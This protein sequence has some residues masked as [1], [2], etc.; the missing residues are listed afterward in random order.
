MQPTD[1]SRSGRPTSPTNRVSPV[2]TPHGAVVVG[3]LPHDDRDRL[4]RVP[5]RVADLELDLT[6][7]QALA[8]GQGSIGKSADAALPYEIAAP[9]D[10]GQLEVTGQEVGVEMRLD[11]PL[12]RQ[13]LGRGFVEVVADVALRV[14]DDSTPGRFV[15][16]HVAEQR[17]ARELVL[18][19]VH[20]GQS[21]P[22][23]VPAA[24]SSWAGYA[25]PDSCGL[26]RSTN[27]ISPKTL[28]N[29]SCD[30]EKS[31]DAS[32]LRASASLLK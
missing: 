17:Q 25:G 4:G 13:P 30:P 27:V 21:I 5:R 15:T 31:S 9:V 22:R 11:D 23:R 8:V 32:P 16:D 10:F 7:R 28:A 3:V 2:R 14:D 24:F 19:E 12:D 18:L 20:V 26:R 6:E 1:V 29:S